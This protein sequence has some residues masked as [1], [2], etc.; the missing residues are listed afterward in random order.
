M[1]NPQCANVM[2]YED[3]LFRSHVLWLLVITLMF[4][5]LH[6]RIRV[7][8]DRNLMHIVRNIPMKFDDNQKK[9]R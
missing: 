5:K 2:T 8:L 7:N 4:N 3:F 6:Q 9:K 1:R